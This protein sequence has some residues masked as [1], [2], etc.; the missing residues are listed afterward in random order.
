MKTPHHPSFQ[1]LVLICPVATLTGFCRTPAGMEDVSRNPNLT[2]KLMRR[3]YSEE[4]IR[5]VFGENFLRV[6]HTA[7]EFAKN[8]ESTPQPVSKTR[9]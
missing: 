4:N 3:G 9:P 7:E 5:K 2:I 6:L 8:R 1:I